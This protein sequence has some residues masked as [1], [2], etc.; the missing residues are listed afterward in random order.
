MLLLLLLLLKII[1]SMRHFVCQCTHLVL[2]CCNGRPFSLVYWF[3][4]LARCSWRWEV[5]ILQINVKQSACHTKANAMDTTWISIPYSQVKSGR[6]INEIETHSVDRLTEESAENKTKKILRKLLTC[7]FDG[8][9][10]AFCLSAR[11]PRMAVTFKWW[12]AKIFIHQ[13]LR[14]SCRYFL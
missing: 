11:W 9:R 6:L 14:Y 3:A 1:N 2:C 4:R 5:N 8:S 13:I 10:L 12:F 7:N